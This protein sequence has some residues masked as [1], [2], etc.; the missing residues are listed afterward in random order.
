LSFGHHEIY[1][2]CKHLEF[3]P[4]LVPTVVAELPEEVFLESDDKPA[5]TNSSVSKRKRDQVSAIVEALCKLRTSCKEAELSQQKLTLMQHQA[6]RG[7]F[8]NKR[9]SV[10][11]SGGS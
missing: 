7:I 10:Q 2:L 4:D 9:A 1:Y 6:T 11:A 5:S 8:Q 3:S